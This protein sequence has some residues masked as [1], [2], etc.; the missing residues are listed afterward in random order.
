MPG[1]QTDHALSTTPQPVSDDTGVASALS[2]STTSVSIGTPSPE[3]ALHVAGSLK[4]ELNGSP[5]LSLFSHGFGSEFYSIRA[6]NDAD[7]AG[8]RRLV[9]RNE[10]RQQ[11]IIVIDNDGNLKLEHNGSPTLALFSHGFGS[12]FYSIRATNDDDNAGGRRLVFR[13]EGR[14][15]DIIVIDNDGNVSFAG[16]IRLTGADCAEHFRVAGDECDPGSVMVIDARET[17]RCCTEPYDP[18]VAGV[19]S[20]A[21]AR[22]P[23]LTLGGGIRDDSARPVALSGTVFCKADATAEPVSVG[24][25]LTTSAN[26]GHAM[27]ASDRTR[28]FGCVLGKAMG[29]LTA[30]V[31]LIPILVTL[32]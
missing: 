12:Q 27:K 6:T 24:D 19:I 1:L 23:G 13:N 20:G 16:D 25:L 21:S 28:A 22:Q 10:G 7:D 18:R 5:T 4:L 15:Q 29:E 17:L 14:Q 32:N 2:L 30:G 3:V 8:G 26:P 9:F 11:D 31:G